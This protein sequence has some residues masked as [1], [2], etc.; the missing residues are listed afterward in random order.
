[1]SAP[2]ETPQRQR[3]VWWS[4]QQSYADNIPS[5]LG[6]VEVG[7]AVYL[8]WWLIPQWFDRH[9]HLVLSV[10]IAPMLLLRSK[11][12]IEAAL[13]GLEA[14]MERWNNSEDVH[15]LSSARG[16]LTIVI[17]GFISFI[18]AN[19][20][21]ENWFENLTEWVLIRNLIMFG[22]LIV[23]FGGLIAI[24]GLELGFLAIAGVVIGFIMAVVIGV[25][26]GIGVIILGVILIA[27]VIGIVVSI[28]L[29]AVI[30]KIL[31][32]VQY[33]H[34]GWPELPN[35]WHRLVFAQDL[36][37]PPELLPEQHTRPTLSKLDAKDYLSCLLSDTSSRS[38]RVSGLLFTIVFIPP[39]WLYRLSLKSTF[40]FYW[41]LVFAQ[42]RVTNLSNISNSTLLETQ[43]KTILG[44]PLLI[45]AMTVIAS[46][47][48]G[49]WTW[50]APLIKTLG[51]GPEQLN[52]VTLLGNQVLLAWP[53]AVISVVLYLSANI[54]GPRANHDSLSA[55][56]LWWLKSLIGLRWFLLW[57]AL[58]CALVLFASQAAPAYVPDPIHAMAE[59]LRLHY[60]GLFV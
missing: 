10:V 57:I 32:T 46:P 8:Y 39:A 29:R 58:L 33:M 30:Q 2:T 38:S 50:L 28:L 51:I 4:S 16:L 37:R 23:V 35:N 27:T 26:S 54:L 60:L 19:W 24:M 25:K 45:L 5:V 11:Q 43:Y 53:V 6:I 52:L 15:K 14:Y 9:W 34:H 42:K 17:V 48:T 44:K 59:W 47:F 7:L 1:M 31:A 12:S 13:D 22:F 21:V 55:G 41:P 40:W 36:Y 56:H 18:M 20:L 3:F 49:F